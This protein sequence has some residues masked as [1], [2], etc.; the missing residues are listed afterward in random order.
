MKVRAALYARVATMQQE[1]EATIE[2]QIA[3]IESYAE[4]HENELAAEHY[5][6]DQVV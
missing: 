2:S 1:Q 5:F 6:L 3:A 4:N